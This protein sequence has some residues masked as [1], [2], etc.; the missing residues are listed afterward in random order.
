VHHFTLSGIDETLSGIDEGWFA[1]QSPS[2]LYE[3]AAIQVHNWGALINIPEPSDCTR[4]RS[5][6][7]LE[8]LERTKSRGF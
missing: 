2:E 1:C 6:T 7:K 4:I 3:L 8:L 5:G